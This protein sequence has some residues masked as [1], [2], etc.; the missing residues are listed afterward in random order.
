MNM[1]KH[2]MNMCIN[3]MY[4]CI[5]MMWQVPDFAAEF[6]LASAAAGS[7]LDQ[8]TGGSAGAVA[9]RGAVT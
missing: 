6:N 4:M 2:M 3:M 9:R 1:C 7:W 8:M 5:H